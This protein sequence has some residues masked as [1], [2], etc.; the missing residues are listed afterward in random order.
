VEN[1]IKLFFSLFLLFVIFFAFATDLPTRQNRGFFSDESGYYSIIQSLA[2]DFD[3]RYERKDLNRIKDI[4]PSGPIGFFIKKVAD[5]H[6]IFAK[7]F[8]YPLVAAPFYKLFSFNG[9]LLLNG[10]MI[11]FSIL[12]AYY[13]LKQFHGQSDSLTFALIFIGASVTPVYI[14]WM[15]ADLFNFFAMFGGLF[16]FF[17]TFKRPWL[18]YVSALFF[19]FSAFSKPWNVAA[20]AIVYLILI[21]RKQW[22]TF[23]ILSAL[24]ALL[25]AGFVGYL[26]SQT[27]Q[28]SYSLFQG[29]ERRSFEKDFPYETDEAPE[30]AF[31]RGNNMSFDRFWSKYDNSPHMIAANLFYFVF[32]RFTGMFIYF[33][34]ACFL[35]FLFFFQ[36][37]EPEDWFILVALISAILLFTQLAAD[38]YFGGSGS[39]GN[40][41]FLNIFP[42]FFFLG[43][44]NRNFKFS[45]I[46]VIIGIIFLSGVHV[47]SHFRSTVPRYNAVSF[48][49]NLFPP[50]KTQYLS[51]PTNENPRAYGK[52]LHDGDKSLQVYIINDGFHEINENHI[53]TNGT[54]PLEFFLAVPQKVDTFRLQLHSQ[55]DNNPVRLDVE[56]KTKR[57]RLMKDSP[58][59]VT[60]KKVAGMK[61]KGRYIYHFKLKSG[62]FAGGHRDAPANNDF[63]K[64]GVRLQIS[65]TY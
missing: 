35:L 12:M 14:W 33:F 59:L 54:M 19:A 53:W 7:S 34:P 26:V 8:A 1:R 36:R 47:D 63:R 17:Y 29:G 43:V 45:L 48:P 50:E 40:R 44:K 62:K 51:L 52:I 42:L 15:T 2:H 60:F 55:T 5:D 57:A 22:E 46:P 16:F 32:G 58:Y 20:I 21:A 4:F 13:L 18:I 6:Y 25:F 10:L 31:Y 9:I 27:G 23:F 49:I 37:K 61:V 64:L 56:Y 30:K 3:I 39:V 38:N 65:V 24:S 28:F 11:F 41:Y